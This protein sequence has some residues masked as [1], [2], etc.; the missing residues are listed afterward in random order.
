MVKWINFDKI[1]FVLSRSFSI[2]ALFIFWLK[3]RAVPHLSCLP[4]LAKQFKVVSSFHVIPSRSCDYFFPP[5][6][7]QQYFY[8]L[9]IFLLQRHSRPRALTKVSQINLRVP[10]TRWRNMGIHW[11][12]LALPPKSDGCSLYL[13]F[14]DTLFFLAHNP[15]CSSRIC[16]EI[17]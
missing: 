6:S 16:I 8:F 15:T 7:L 13:P 9:R 12:R 17:G 3:I 14:D 4:S 11:A 5:K 1:I 10:K 2:I